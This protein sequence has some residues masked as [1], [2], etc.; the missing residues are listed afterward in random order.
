MSEIY[1]LKRMVA[2]KGIGLAVIVI[3]VYTKTMIFVPI[4]TDLFKED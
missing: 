2:E 3:D 1:G 4:V